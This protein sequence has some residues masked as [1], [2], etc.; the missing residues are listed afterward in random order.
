MEIQ[1]RDTAHLEIVLDSRTL[2]GHKQEIADLDNVIRNWTDKCSDAET[3]SVILLSPPDQATELCK[4]AKRKIEL[5][6]KA[7]EVPITFANRDFPSKGTGDVADTAAQ[8]SHLKDLIMLAAIDGQFDP[9]EQQIILDIGLKMGLSERQI[10]SVYNQSVLNPDAIE[11]VAPKD[12][13]KRRQQLADLCRVILADG[14]LNDWESVLIF[15]L[16]AKMGFDAADIT[17]MLDDLFESQ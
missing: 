1:R 3:C 16:A 15:P 8:K 17:S 9:A 10:N 14:E 6:E 7:Y 5:L 4:I 2:E 12:P 11:S 13:L